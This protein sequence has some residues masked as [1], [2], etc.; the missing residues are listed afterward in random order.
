MA[1]MIDAAKVYTRSTAAWRDTSVEPCSIAGN[2]EGPMSLVVSHPLRK[3]IRR[4]HHLDQ[5]LVSYWRR[6]HANGGKSAPFG[7]RQ[8]S[9]R[10][11]DV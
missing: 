9:F 10:G 4:S 5:T 6:K 3:V 11:Q 1:L 2:L 7:S 8:T